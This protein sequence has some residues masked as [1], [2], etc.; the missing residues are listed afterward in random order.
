MDPLVDPYT[1]FFTNAEEGGTTIGLCA[2]MLVWFV[3]GAAA[4]RF[5][6]LRRESRFVSQK[7]V[8]DTPQVPVGRKQRAREMEKAMVPEK[9]VAAPAPAANPS[10]EQCSNSDDDDEWSD[11]EDESSSTDGSD[12]DDAL[13]ELKLKMVLIVRKDEPLLPGPCIATKASEAALAVL[14]KTYVTYS[15]NQALSGTDRTQAVSTDTAER[16]W[17]WYLWWNRIGVAKITL[18]CPDRR[19]LLD[20]HAKAVESNLPCA[21]VDSDI[22]AVGPAPSKDLD[23]I[24]G[25]LK[26]LS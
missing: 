20:L 17:R 25:S 15:A 21:L 5:M 18:K 3:V 12:S 14:H 24:S 19:T 6:Y 1:V 10:T 2:C 8:V 7:A 26:L 22:L 23:V 11:E 4:G 13:E 16:W 9:K